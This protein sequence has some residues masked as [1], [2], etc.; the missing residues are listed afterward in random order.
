MEKQRN[1]YRKVCDMEHMF[2]AGSKEW[3]IWFKEHA[4]KKHRL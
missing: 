3:Q 4:V 2:A 1:Q